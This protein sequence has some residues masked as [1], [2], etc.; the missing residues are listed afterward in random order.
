[1]FKRKEKKSFCD[2]ET[3]LWTLIKDE[4]DT[5][6]GTQKE[7]SFDGEKSRGRNQ[8]RK[9]NKAQ[10]SRAEGGTQSRLDDSEREDAVRTR[11]KKK[12][13][14][15]LKAGKHAK[16]VYRQFSGES[17]R[18]MLKVEGES[19]PPTVN[20]ETEVLLRVEVRAFLVQSNH[21]L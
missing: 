6:T 1:M 13:T 3:T 4:V 19:S 21:F 9:A 2:D 17:A 10:E 18:G 20:S 15:Q 5:L 12:I 11:R 16:V 14:G 7:E 8:F